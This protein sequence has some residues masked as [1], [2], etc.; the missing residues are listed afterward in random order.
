MTSRER[1]RAVLEGRLPDRLPFNFW[2]DRDRMAAL[3]RELSGN[4]RVSHYGADVIETFPNLGFFPG[5]GRAAGVEA[6]AGA[7]WPDADDPKCYA[8]IRADRA[9][10]PDKALFALMITPL[11]VL[12]NKVGMEQLFYDFAD[13]GELVDD[14]L[15]RISRVLLQAVDHI[16][17]CD[18]DVLYL[19]GDICASR[20]ELMSSDMLRRYCFGPVRR[21]IERAHER[22]LKV[23]FHTDGHVMNILPLFVEY[24]LDGINPLQYSVNNS[25]EVFA[26]QYGDQLMLYGGLDNCF[27]L[28][29]GTPAQVR[30]HVRH[31]FETCGKHGRLIASSHDIPFYAPMENLE[32][33][34]DEIKRCVY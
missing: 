8:G 17:G 24:G 29:D 20:G 23:F 22:G 14:L 12:F 33:M 21:L 31:L 3:D 2:M 19:A 25:C 18:V 16:A 1:V 11:E 9:K 26:A 6:L 5:R 34:V 7:A 27:I 4:F 28:P 15:E 30:A 13:D 10:Y 32:A